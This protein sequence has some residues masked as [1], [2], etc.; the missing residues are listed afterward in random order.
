MVLTAKSVST[1]HTKAISTISIWFGKSVIEFC[2]TVVGFA[3][4]SATN[5]PVRFIMADTKSSL[6]IQKSFVFVKQSVLISW[7]K[8]FGKKLQLPTPQVALPLWA[9]S[10]IL[11]TESPNSIL[12]TFF[13][14]KSRATRP[15][16]PKNK[17]SPLP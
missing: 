3:L 5:S 1:T 6:F 16:L 10:P 14:S 4:T 13:F 2:M 11:E 9:A 15:N 12:S 17:K 7:G 8:S